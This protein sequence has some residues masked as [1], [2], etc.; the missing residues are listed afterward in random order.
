MVRVDLIGQGGGRVGLALLVTDHMA[1]VVQQRCNDECVIASIGQ[2][3]RLQL[4]LDHRD[5]LAEVRHAA[6]RIERSLDRLAPPRRSASD[7]FIDPPFEHRNRR[8]QSV[9]ICV[10]ALEV[11]RSAA[12]FE[13]CASVEDP[14]VVEDDAVAGFELHMEMQLG[15]IEC[16]REHTQSA[17]DLGDVLR[18]HRWWLDRAVVPPDGADVA[19]SVEAMIGPLARSNVSE[20]SYLNVRSVVVERGERQGIR[21]AHQTRPRRTRRSKRCRHRPAD[22]CRQC[23]NWMPGTGSRYGLSVCGAIARPVNA[24]FTGWASTRTS[25]RSP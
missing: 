4:V 22:D 5:V 3:A 25:N 8:R 9:E 16:R 10:A 15:P 1:D 24:R 17:I 12:T 14:G 13:R 20:S 11:P 23:S 19:G 2:R 6:G 18:L 7:S 21:L